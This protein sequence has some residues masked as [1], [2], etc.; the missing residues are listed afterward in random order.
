MVPWLNGSRKTKEIETLRW[1][2]LRRFLIFSLK[3]PS[4]GPGFSFFFGFLSKSKVTN[5]VFVRG[6]KF[7]GRFLIDF[8]LYR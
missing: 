5:H 7:F 8:E 6:Y 4:R 3:G 2:C 1:F